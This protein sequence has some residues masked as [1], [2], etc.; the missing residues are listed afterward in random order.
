MVSFFWAGTSFAAEDLDLFNLLETVEIF[1][2]DSSP[3]TQKGTDWG[4]FDIADGTSTRFFKIK[5]DG[6]EDLIIAGSQN[7]NTANFT[8]VGLP[9]PLQPIAPDST[10]T[11]YIIFDPASLGQKNAEIGII[12]SDPNH[13][14]FTFDITAN[15]IGFPEIVVEGRF[16]SG[17]AWENI[18]DGDTTPFS[19]DGTFWT[20]FV[21]PGNSES[22]TFRIRN[23]GDDTLTIGLYGDDS[24]HFFASGISSSI[25]PGLSDLFTVT[26]APQDRG[27]HIATISIS[28]NDSNE[29]P[30]NFDVRG[31]AQAP[32]ITIVG[33]PTFLYSIADGDTSPQT[34]DG[35]YFGDHDIDSGAISTDFRMRN[36]GD[37]NLDLTSATITG[38]DNDQFSISGVISILPPTESDT[39][40]VSFN[41]TSAGYKQAEVRIENNDPNENPYTFAIAGNGTG[42]PEIVVEGSPDALEFKEISSGDSTPA[43]VDGTEFKSVAGGTILGHTFR[44]ANSGTDTLTLSASDNSASFSITGLASSLQPGQD[45]EFEVRFA[46]LSAGTKNGVITLNNNSS[47]N[48]TFTFAVSGVGLAPEIALF[49]GPSLNSLILDGD[50]SPSTGDG[51]DFGLAERNTGMVTNTFK[52]KNEGNVN[53]DVSSID[54]EGGSTSSFEVAHFNPGI[55]SPGGMM[56]FDLIFDP[57]TT[58]FASYDITINNNDPDEEEYTFRVGG[59]GVTAPILEVKGAESGQPF[60]LITN[61]SSSAMASNGTLYQDTDFGASVQNI[62]QFANKGSANLNFAITSSDPQFEIVNTRTSL[63]SLQVFDFGIRFTPTASGLQTTTISIDSNDAT[64]DP[65]TFVL[66]GTTLAGK[67]RVTGLGKTILNGDTTP[68]TIDGTEFGSVLASSTAVTR[69]YQIQNI[70]NAILDLGAASLSGNTGDFALAPLAV[71]SLAINESTDLALTF[72]PTTTG[73]STVV[74]AIPTSDPEQDPFTFT[75]SG[76]RVN[77]LVGIPDLEICGNGIGIG[78]GD[79]SP[80]IADGT[81][82]GS[83]SQ[84]SGLVSRTFVMKNRGTAIGAPPG[85][86]DLLSIIVNSNHPDVTFA[87]VPSALRSGNSDTFTATFNPVT[88]GLQEAIISVKSNDPNESPYTFAIQIQVDGPS[89]P[90]SGIID[91]ALDFSGGLSLVEFAT[92]VGKVYEVRTSSNLAA[93]T[94]SLVPGTSPL[95]G[96]GSV[97][98]ISFIIPL[99]GNAPSDPKRFYRLE[100]CPAP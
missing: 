22:H 33:G 32:D 21:N 48:S 43:V 8:V 66:Q 52:I 73:T 99:T 97:E 79:H 69:R 30:F 57:F 53:L 2:G 94:W 34:Q 86:S 5:N 95:S 59:L 51:T 92:E 4:D 81:D 76:E 96:T 44:V 38:A 63:F 49:G 75:V 36:V 41:P 25:G 72:E 80:E 62:F 87:S 98:S 24:A 71:S 77:S 28:N 82:Y 18:Q 13:N 64:N 84:G 1:H 27:T 46:P 35:T 3:T 67:A 23:T 20:S 58:G 19:D 90:S 16:A 61:G 6:N 40:A 39:F 50:S 78:A 7:S 17:S 9:T 31:V 12:S 100:E 85:A 83:V 60:A 45:D 68:A 47:T 10:A 56:T 11:F 91:C 93:G 37:L 88:V 54:V 65:F 55:V 42:T 29:D 70:G 15:A 26:F 89:G 74:V 14:P